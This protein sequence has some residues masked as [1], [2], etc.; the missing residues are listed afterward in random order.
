MESTS[1][2]VVSPIRS[3]ARWVGPIAL[4]AVFVVA[5]ASVLALNAYISLHR[6][7]HV[8]NGFSV[9]VLVC[10]EDGQQA[11][12]PPGGRVTLTIGEGPHE[13]SVTANGRPL[14]SG[15]F[16]VSST[17]LARFF[18]QPV[19]V[20]NAGCGATVLWEETVYGKQTAGSMRLNAGQPFVMFDNVDFVFAQ[21]PK[22]M[23]TAGIPAKKTR[24]ELFPLS[25][26]Q[27]MTAPLNLLSVSDRLT[28]AEAHLQ[29]KPD[30]PALLA[31]Y[32]QIS[33]QHSQGQRAREFL[34]AHALSPPAHVR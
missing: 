22:T 16:E 34:A 1:N 23:K 15:P 10:L 3:R 21:F 33:E 11:E 4:A 29:L 27:V 24:V 31:A 9:P 17:L 8:V 14:T 2:D 28:L 26:E 18:K 32:L 5:A 12:V 7:L 25:A 6:D 13:A 30:D 20:L 19:F